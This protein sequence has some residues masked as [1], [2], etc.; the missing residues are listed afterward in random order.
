MTISAID[1]SG[2]LAS[3]L[4]D[5][6]RAFAQASFALAQPVPALLANRLLSTPEVESVYIKKIDNAFHV[7]TIVDTADDAVLEVIFEGEKSLM[8]RFPSMDFDFNVV[9]RRGQNLRSV[10]TLSCQGWTKGH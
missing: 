8:E 2:I 3:Q 9:E 1:V 5:N 6:A 7:W 4:S 10:I